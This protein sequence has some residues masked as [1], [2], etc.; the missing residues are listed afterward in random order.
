[1][2]VAV[3]FAVAGANAATPNNDTSVITCDG[4][5]KFK[6]GDK[7]QW[8]A[9]DFNDAGWELV[10][11]SAP[12]GAHDG[13]VGLSGYVP[14]WTAKGHN[15]YSGFAWYRL[16]ISLPAVKGA[17]LAI[18]GPPAVDDA[19][20]LFV[21][22]VLLGSAGDFSGPV[23]VAYSI[24]PQLFLL[25]DSLKNKNQVTIAFRVWMSKATI[26]QLPDAGGIHIAPVLGEQSSV[27]TIYKFQWG[28][29]IKGYIAEVI[30]PAIFILLALLIFILYKPRKQYKWFVMALI[31]LALVRTNQ[32]VF[33]WLQIE[34]AHAFD[35][36]TTV[37]LIPLVL[38]SWL[39]AWW[40]WHKL[41]R[42]VWV[43]RVILL[44]TFI[45]M[46]VQLLGLPWVAESLPHTVFDTLSKAIR[47]VFVLLLLYIIYRGIRQR[48]EDKG[49][50]LLATLLVATGLFAPELSALHIQGI[51]F[52]FGVGVSRSQY[53]YMAFDV[54]LFI[55]LIRHYK[56]QKQD[57]GVF[58]K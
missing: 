3:L 58:K 4:P 41:V 8:S 32:A 13:D 43:P 37:I 15:D 35:L 6:T 57:P 50:V 12:P 24:R 5:W 27:E 51:W 46:C 10:D 48:T 36:I 53:A 25:P 26:S 11:L 44:L 33:Y 38:G 45:Y 1:M 17:H 34:S 7:P 22:G 14:G 42:P 16:K 47:L 30:L 52:P 29:T 9:P 18:A 54:I 39:L 28:Q 20:Q 2:T 31:L 23:P 40:H 56:R 49:L 19:Y 55:I 21:N